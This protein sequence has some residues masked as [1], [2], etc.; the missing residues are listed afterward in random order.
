MT[1]QKRKILLVADMR[2]PHASS[3]LLGM[4][5]MGLDVV[6][7]SSKRLTTSERMAVAGV[8]GPSNVH[9]VDSHLAN[10][11]HLATG[12]ANGLA[13]RLFRTKSGTT[14]RAP[15]GSGRLEY[16]LEETIARSL[17][18]TIHDIYRK[19]DIGLIHALRIPFEGIA[20]D[21][22]GV[23]PMAVSI[24]GQ[25]LVSQARANATL[26]KR[27]VS[28][29]QSAFGIH[30]DCQRDLDL[31]K[32]LRNN[33]TSK[34]LLAPG[35]MGYDEDIFW[36][37]RLMAPR[38]KIVVMPRGAASHIAVESWLSA[39]DIVAR[40]EPTAVFIAPGLA[41]NPRAESQV[42]ASPF[43]DR[44]NL[45]RKLDAKKLSQLFRRADIICSPARND[46]T[47]NS[48][49]EAMAC[50]AIPVVG[51]VESLSALLGARYVELEAEAD[52]PELTAHRVIQWLGMPEKMKCEVRQEM[53]RI[54]DAWSKS[55][56]RPR[57]RQWYY[58]LMRTHA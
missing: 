33:Q 35:N 43:R 7:L 56:S 12:S 58:Q 10:V 3:W 34:L 50:G 19:G 25:D 55:R 41:G 27:S 51:R 30:A 11:R 22:A 1:S 39:V 2:S 37:P 36:Q 46:G 16:R 45:T 21:L 48:V 42:A 4:R 52:S 40:A 32:E 9:E 47:P 17:A 29:L 44:I 54:A 20:A 26:M 57:V 31:A 24:W 18:A 13:Q 28:T 53:G 49:V 38:E 5:A 23:R 15:E 14:E 6:V 8:A